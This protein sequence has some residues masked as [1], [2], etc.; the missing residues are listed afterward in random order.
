MT[1]SDATDCPAGGVAVVGMAGR[2]PGCGD[3]DGLWRVLRDGWEA[4]SFLSDDEL[5]AAGEDPAVLAESNY[6]KAAGV[7]ADIDKFDAGFFGF[8]PKEAALLDPQQRIFLECAW[9]ALEHAGYSPKAYGGSIGVYAGTGWN[10]Y[11]LFHVASH[12]T[13]LRP[14]TRHQALLGNEKDNLALRVSYKLDLKGPSLTVQTGCSTSLVTAALAFHGLLSYQCDM[15]LAGGVSIRVPQAGYLYQ[16]EGIFSPDG[17]CRAFDAGARGTVLGS[18]AGVVVLKRLEDAIADGDSIYAVLKGVAVNNDGSLKPGFTAPSVEGQAAVIREAQT[19]AGVSPET[20]TYI[21]A[22]GSGTALGDPIEFAALTQ[23]FRAGTAKRRYCAIGSIKTNL[24]HLDAAAGV[25]GLIKTVLALQHRQIPPSLHFEEANPEIDFA[26]SPFYVST[27]LSTWNPVGMPR[28]AGVSSFGLGGT[29]AHVILEEAPEAE[30]SEPDRT[31]QLLL[32]SAKTAEALDRVTSALSN[33]LRRSPEN[34]LADAAYT[35]QIGRKAFAHRRMLIC[36]DTGDAATALEQRNP[37]RVRTRWVNPENRGV[38]F[39]FSGQGSQYAGMAHGLYTAEPAFREPADLCFAILRSRHGLDLHGLFDDPQARPPGRS[40][41]PIPRTADAQ[42]ALFVVEYSL[43]RLWMSWGLGMTA[44]LG[45]SLGEYVAAT[46][47]GVFTLEDALSILAERGRLLQALPPGAMLAVAMQADELQP[48]LSPE[49]SLAAINESGSCVV[50][51]L[52]EAVKALRQEL[53]SLRIETHD[54]KVAH[55]FHSSRMDPV[56]KPF[57]EHL[58]LV[59]FHPPCLPW[60]STVTGDWMT[61]AEATDP[62]H[63]VRHLRQPV[64]F[65]DGLSRLL[66]DTDCLL[67]EVGPGRTLT[68][69]ASRHPER[70]EGR[71]MPPSLRHSQDPRLDREVLLH[72]L[73]ELWLAGSEVDW[74]AFHRHRR[75]RRVPL[76]TYPFDRQRHWISP[77]PPEPAASQDLWSALVA[78]GGARAT[79][80]IAGFDPLAQR[81]RRD[82]LDRLSVG[83]M[84]LAFQ[85]LG[86][87]G[88]ADP[89]CK[90]QDLPELD[91]VLPR[92]RPLLRHCLEIL[93]RKGQVQRT[94]EGTLMDFRPCSAADLEEFRAD[95]RAHWGTGSLVVDRVERCGEALSNVL[96]GRS[97]PLELFVPDLEEARTETPPE[98]A[99]GTEYAAIL[100]SA[101]SCAVQHMSPSARLRILEIGGGTGLATRELLPVLPPDRTS[102]TF[103]DVGR[104][105]IARAR[106]RFGGHPFVRYGILD[107][108]KPPLPQGYP[109]QAFDIVVA[110]N[111]LHVARDLGQALNRVRS[112]LAPGGLLL[113]GEVTRPTPD[114]AITYGLLMNE[115]AD[116]ERDPGNPFLSPEQWRRALASHGFARVEFFP[117]GDVFG[118]HALI[119]QVAPAGSPELLAEVFPA[120]R[121]DVGDWFYVPSW[122]RSAPLPLAEPERIHPVSR[123]QWLLFVNGCGLGESLLELLTRRGEK[124]VT[125]RAGDRYHRQTPNNFEIDPRNRADYDRLLRD[126]KEEVSVPAR[127]VHLWGITADGPELTT[128]LLAED[129]L[130]GFHSLLFLAQAIGT[131]EITDPLEIVIVTN[132]QQEVTDDRVAAE[133]ALM[134]APCKVVPIEYPNVRCRS[135]DVA[136]GPDGE[137]PRVVEQ[138]LRELR[139]ESADPVV[140]YRGAHRWVRT[141][142]PVRLP[143]PALD[144]SRLRE[145]GVYLIT[146][147]LGKIGLTV[148][149]FLARTV[150]ARL[151]LLGRSEIPPPSEW[152]RSRVLRKLHAIEAL[153]AEVLAVSADVADLERMRAVIAAAEERFGA[154]HGVIHSAG[155]L[156]DGALQEKTLKDVNSVL[157]PKVIG[158]IVLDTLFRDHSLDF[159]VLFS[160]LSALR[161]AFGQ[162]A[163]AAANCFLDAV[164]YSLLKR[165]H[166]FTTCINWDVWQEEGMAYDAVA[167]RV[168][169][170]MKEEEFKERGILPQEGVEVLA[171]ILASDLPQV[172]VSTSDDLE[173]LKAGDHDPSRPYFEK[174]SSAADA[175]H[176]Q[177]RPWLKTPYVPPATE[178]EE[179]LAGLWE[180]LLG[181][182]KIGVLDDFFEL[183]GDSLVG[184][185]LISRVKSA[186][187]MQLPVRSLYSH[188][189]VRSLS[190]AAERALLANVSPERIAGMLR[191]LGGAEPDVSPR[192]PERI[193]RP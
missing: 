42:L 22:H 142:E 60:V 103:T 98:R 8:S 37:R 161:P 81:A 102:Y 111:V 57:A 24:G 84:N 137:E 117:E 27:S 53:Q 145:R 56:L 175:V 61:A 5:T 121:P 96:C 171:R 115:P 63:W 186:C 26:D 109:G 106:E 144:A 179:R 71:V 152:G 7:L 3:I 188:P 35:L 30:V 65:A 165:R 18:G 168:L 49:L 182:E 76:P 133:K 59:R 173:R 74:A 169:Q 82:S 69:L 157:A 150:R 66:K 51:G 50:S 33:H 155:I 47:A 97:E 89:V 189:T 10:G 149:E 107:L 172:L 73:G 31:P 139:S 190:Q 64:L 130:R 75:R 177:A 20:I 148:A 44:A 41:E 100:A 160:S 146:G 158:T 54:L 119:A 72:A 135:V 9:A 86:W 112:L 93:A 32:L 46:L 126:L 68:G 105:F 90:P 79:L 4:I 91:R 21:E 6:V 138:I 25:A 19:M 104:L 129:R 143:K 12:R 167:P 118:N 187:G 85:R 192:A 147:G 88:P 166:R 39:L 29:N 77:A 123:A 43:A 181:I 28:R 122:K 156:G 78:A 2:F 55:P 131:R 124:V 140:A 40:G 153:G 38:A 113:M 163:Y 58:S 70:G 178:T 62:G 15:A 16:S 134:L 92:F 141:V 127:V 14:E 13:L 180:E 191:Q 162:V 17:H 159:L 174:L 80:E 184:T 125:V 67:L 170:R 36:E 183:G 154:I 164:P 83:Y 34:N 176:K 128:E 48:R 114:F 101:L 136:V 95:A 87:P 23:A 108:E 1:S 193:V 94:P 120:K 99:F 11:F 151:I 185:Q 116:E 110:A 52:P 45:H 132:G